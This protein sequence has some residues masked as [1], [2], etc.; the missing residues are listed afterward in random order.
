MYNRIKGQ[1]TET[2]PLIIPK[3]STRRNDRV[4]IKNTKNGVE[5]KKI[6]ALKD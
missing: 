4:D 5:T 1:E 6:P 3:H 2:A